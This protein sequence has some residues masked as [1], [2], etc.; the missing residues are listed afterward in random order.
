MKV[1]GKKDRFSS[2]EPL[3][4]EVLLFMSERELIKIGMRT[5]RNTEYEKARSC[6]SI[7][8]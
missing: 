2:G 7:A 6:F 1:S 5:L 8:Q 4:E 3:D